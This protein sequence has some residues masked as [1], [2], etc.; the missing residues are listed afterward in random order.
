MSRFTADILTKNIPD[1]VLVECNDEWDAV[2]VFNQAR[3][4]GELAILC[5]E[6]VANSLTA[7]QCSLQRN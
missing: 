1:G 5:R 4:L 6:K 3:H 7:W 2:R